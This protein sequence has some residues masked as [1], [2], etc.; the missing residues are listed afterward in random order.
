MRLLLRPSM[1]G[2]VTQLLFISLPATTANNSIVLRNT[3]SSGALLTHPPPCFPPP[4]RTLH[5]SSSLPLR[6]CQFPSSRIRITCFGD[7]DHLDYL[8]ALRWKAKLIRPTHMSGGGLTCVWV[9]PRSASAIV[10]TMVVLVELIKVDG[11]VK[12]WV[13]LTMIK[14]RFYQRRI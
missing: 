2:S 5:P 7:D 12:I 9:V 11:M 6:A 14:I 1:S 8:I 3:R 13:L 10:I 4:H